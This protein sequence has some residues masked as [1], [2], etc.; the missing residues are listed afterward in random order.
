MMKYYCYLL[1]KN[2]ETKTQVRKVVKFI[3]LLYNE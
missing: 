3:H 2:E 1:F